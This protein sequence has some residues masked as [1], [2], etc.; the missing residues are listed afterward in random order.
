MKLNY[1]Y[2]YIYVYINF[3]IITGNI[4]KI[5]SNKIL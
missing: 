5:L 4:N 3:N 1:I 2:I